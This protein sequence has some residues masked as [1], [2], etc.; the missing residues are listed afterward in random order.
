MP[1]RSA[2]SS[3]QGVAET[4]AAPA[5]GAGARRHDPA[6]AASTQ[7]TSPRLTRSPERLALHRPTFQALAINMPVEARLPDWWRAR[8]LAERSRT[9]P[10]P[11]SPRGPQPVAGLL[12]RRRVGIQLL[13]VLH[14]RRR[15]VP[16]AQR[17]RG[18]REA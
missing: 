4:D 15:L 3:N 8:L 13:C 17:H 10:L 7:N 6:T 16:P 12:H 2:M 14:G 9:Q 11:S 5:G 1:A 18:V